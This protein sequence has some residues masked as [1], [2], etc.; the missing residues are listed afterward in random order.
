MVIEQGTKSLLIFGFMLVLVIVASCIILLWK[1]TKN[2]ALLWFIPQLVMLS[3]CL[4]L[5]IRLIDTQRAIPPAMLSEENSLNIGLIGIGWGLSMLFMTIGIITSFKK[6][7][8][9]D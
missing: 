4:F 6:R 9:L 3:I 2:N 8:R 7:T 5:F 1:K